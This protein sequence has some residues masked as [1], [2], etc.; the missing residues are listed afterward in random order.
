MAHTVFDMIILVKYSWVFDAKCWC[1]GDDEIP[2]PAKVDV[3]KPG[4]IS[5]WN[6]SANGCEFLDAHFPPTIILAAVIV[7]KY[8]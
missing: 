1:K 5:V 7:L 8:S 4:V 6:Q 2:S 3:G